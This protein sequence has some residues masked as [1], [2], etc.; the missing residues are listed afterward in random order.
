MRFTIFQDSRQGDRKGNED[1]V[2]YSYS[3]DVLLMT[4][5]D[6][7]GG[8]ADGEVAAEIAI[9]EIT[10][11]FQQEARNK[12]RKPFDFLVSA[13]QSAH[14]AIVSH[15]VAHNLLECPRTTIVAC[16]VQNGNAYW[17]H[18]GDSRMYILR[19]GN[20]VAATQDHSRV[21]LM[22]DA[23]EITEEMAA[24]HP[25]RNKI[26]SCLGGVV[27]PQIATGREF[28]LEA[29]DTII[30]STDG[31]WAQIPA[32]ILGSMLRKQTLVE[33]LPGLLGEAQ[34]RAR[35]ESDNL[36]VVAM[37][38][39]NQDDPRLP[40]T[41]QMEEDFASSS[42]T[43][44]QLDVPG[45]ADEDVTDEDIERAINEIQDAIRKVPR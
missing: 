37:T 40:D 17:A 25:E 20:L 30:L 18:A 33:L 6:G 31:F 10:R 23:G 19:R 35:G 9:T 39:E 26:F 8:H 11:R 24:R 4:I 22:I 27:P 5:A 29:G 15:A 42:N 7:M 45:V 12:L 41:T 38:W 44:E 1:R 34:R 32:N 43:T 36:S 13:I 3:R 14:R 16:I 2:G 21:Q 28:P